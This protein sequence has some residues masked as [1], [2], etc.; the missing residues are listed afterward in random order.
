M[1]LINLSQTD[2]F[3]NASNIIET[4]KCKLDYK[5]LDETYIDD[6]VDFINMNY[7][8]NKNDFTLVYSHKLIKYY[9]I[10]S[11]PIFFY[12]KNRP[13]KIIALII[14]KYKKI[15]MFN[16]QLPMIE[17]NFFCIIPQLR[18]LNLPILLKTYLIR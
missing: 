5:I 6:I 12:A 16:K 7:K 13:T 10:D 4:H 15:M 17:G 3:F 9:L 14:G 11:I 18:K 2:A 1:E 8:D